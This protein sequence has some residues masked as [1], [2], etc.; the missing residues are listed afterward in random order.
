MWEILL[1]PEQ[2]DLRQ[3]MQVSWSQ[4]KRLHSVISSK[5]SINSWQNKHNTLCLT[6]GRGQVTSTCSLVKGEALSQE[7]DLDLSGEVQVLKQTHT[8]IKLLLHLY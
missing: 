7:R 3:V 6:C 4:A 1:Q 5:Y 8:Y 2:I